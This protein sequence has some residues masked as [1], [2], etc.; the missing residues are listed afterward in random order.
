[1]LIKQD[2]NT[3]KVIKECCWNYSAKPTGTKIDVKFGSHPTG[4]NKYMDSS[5]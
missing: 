5:I 3:L 4:P 1:V 2:E